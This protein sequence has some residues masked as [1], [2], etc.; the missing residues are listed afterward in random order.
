[1]RVIAIGQK[2]TGWL[3]DGVEHY[4]KRLRNP[5]M[6]EWVILP[7]SHDI[8]H[9][10]AEDEAKRILNRL[11]QDDFVILLDETGKMLTSNQFSEQLASAQAMNKQVVF[12]IGGS[13]GVSPTLFDRAD[14]T[15]SISRMV[16]PH[17]LVRLILAE[18]VYR[19]QTIS[20]NHPYHHA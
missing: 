4:Q 18:Q 7:N 6:L 9:S 3:A 19:A 2:S 1:M 17:Q 8:G 12:I 11:K 13:Y 15:L 20:V 14:F 16:F 5:F 10:G